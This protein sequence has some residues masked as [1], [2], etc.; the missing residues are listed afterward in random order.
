MSVMVNDKILFFASGDFAIPTFKS[1]IKHNYNIVG[2]VT[3]NDKLMFPDKSENKRLVDIALENNIPTLVV[4][5]SLND[6][7]IYKWIQKKE[8][9][10]FCVISF[11]YIPPIMLKCAKKVAFNVHGSLLP[12]FR[13]AAPIH[14]ALLNGFEET[15]LT[16][17]ILNDKIDSGKIIETNKIAIYDNDDFRSLFSKMSDKCAEFTIYVIEKI[18]M[19]GES[20]YIDNAYDQPVIDIEEKHKVAPKIGP[21]FAYKWYHGSVDDAERYFKVIRPLNQPK[22]RFLLTDKKTGKQKHLDITVYDC[23]FVRKYEDVPVIESDLKTYLKFSPKDAEWIC[24][25]TDLQIAG[26][27]HVNLD[28]FLRGF[29]NLYKNFD[30]DIEEVQD[31]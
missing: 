2:L 1:M 11:K 9:D 3:S 16:A 21:D 28:E 26:K 5:S 20:Y 30:F 31:K 24:S 25:I 18:A 15:G 27:K 6:P 17:F 12:Y 4:G 23:S 19:F 10:I 22:V 13:G 7:D 29:T 8:A 14:H